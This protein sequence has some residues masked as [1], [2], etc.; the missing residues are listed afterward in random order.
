ML[1]MNN[2]YVSNWQTENFIC[3][4]HARTNSEVWINLLMKW[5]SF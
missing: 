1:T 4:I 2:K 3:I 5:H